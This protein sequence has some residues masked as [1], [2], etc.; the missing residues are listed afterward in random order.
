LCGRDETLERL[1]GRLGFACAPA[2]LYEFDRRPHSQIWL[3]RVRRSPRRRSRRLVTAEAIV[4]R[5]SGP[6]GLAPCI[7]GPA[8]RG[9]PR[10][11]SD[12]WRGLG[13]PAPERGNPQGRVRRDRGTDRVGD[14]IGLGDRRDGACQVATPRVCDAQR[15]EVHRQVSQ[16]TSIPEHSYMSGGKFELPTVGPDSVTRL[17]GHPPPPHDVVQ[18]EVVDP[19]GRLL[20]RRAGG[21]HAV[22]R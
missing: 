9:L 13:L 15:I 7:S 4:Q 8:G 2:G 1:A 11:A 3:G 6:M 21:G 10:D 5:R 14:T 18:R 20:Q 16:R 12:E 19:H 22:H 17:V